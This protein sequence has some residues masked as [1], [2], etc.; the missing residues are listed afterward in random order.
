M[1]Q[2]GRNIQTLPRAHTCLVPHLHI[3]ALVHNYTVST[4]NAYAIISHMVYHLKTSAY[5][6]GV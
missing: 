6:E 5:I 2:W 3:R 4:N 1:F